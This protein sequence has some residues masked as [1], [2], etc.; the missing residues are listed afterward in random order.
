M[1]QL[2]E[3]TIIEPKAF[4]WQ[5]YKPFSLW[6]F[7]SFMNRLDVSNLYDSIHYL[8]KMEMA[9]ELTDKTTLALSRPL[10]PLRD[11]PVGNSS[12]EVS[13]FQIK[14]A[15]QLT[16]LNLRLTARKF[17]ELLILWGVPPYRNDRDYTRKI[18]QAHTDLENTL[19]AELEDQYLLYFDSNKVEFFRNPL[20]GWD[21]VVAKLG[22]NAQAEIEEAGKCLSMNRPTASV[23]HLCRLFEM[24]FKDFAQ[25]ME[26]KLSYDIGSTSWEQL[27]R[28]ML[29]EIKDRLRVNP[30][31]ASAVAIK[32]VADQLVIVKNVIR[33]ETIHNSDHT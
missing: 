16:S 24:G 17:A 32:N 26:V 28:D 33:N 27:N 23:F 5:T 7:M 20:H 29:K 15:K 6:E 12:D 2:L 31:D 18:V 21:D 4:I 25:D 19:R 22:K 1:T 3:S 14:F 10:N 30:A 9:Q 13:D 11:E 8:G